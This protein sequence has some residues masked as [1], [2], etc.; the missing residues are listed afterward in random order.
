[1]VFGNR[2][3]K[4]AFI[5]GITGQ[6]GA[7]RAEL[8]LAKGN[9]SPLRGKEFLTRKVSDGIARIRLGKLDT[10]ELGNLDAKRDLGSHANMWTGCEACSRSNNPTPSCLPS[11]SEWLSPR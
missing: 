3:M 8:L 1:M 11:E 7:Y 4:K 6:D 5:T 9:E 10:L 2:G